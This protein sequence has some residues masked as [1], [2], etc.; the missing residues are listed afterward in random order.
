MLDTHIILPYVL[1]GL[2]LLYVLAKS[3][4]H[5]VKLCSRSLPTSVVERLIQLQHIPAV[6]YPGRLMSYLELPRYLLRSKDVVDEG[7]RKVS[8]VLQV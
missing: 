7:Y 3:G 2:I 4:P 6:G 1:V 5:K 8:F